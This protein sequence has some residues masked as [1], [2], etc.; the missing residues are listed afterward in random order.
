MASTAR[1]VR[2][3]LYRARSA[4]KEAGPSIPSSADPLQYL[5][6]RL[7]NLPQIFPKPILIHR[8]LRRLIPEAAGVRRNLIGQDQFAVVQ[9]KLQ[10]EIDEDHLS[11]T[12]ERT[13]D[14]I[15]L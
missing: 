13:E 7:F 3:R 1:I 9:P 15:H 14:P 11:F 5:P 10:F 6:I 8:L 2:A 4:S 12:E